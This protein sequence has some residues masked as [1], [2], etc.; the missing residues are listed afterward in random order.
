M[1]V[2]FLNH[3]IH[4]CGVYQYGLRLYNILSKSNDINYIYEE[5]DSFSEYYNVI[6]NNNNIKKILYNYHSCT[7]AWLN[8]KNINKQINS[9]G[10]IHESDGSF[11]DI[12]CNIN[13]DEIEINKSFS[14]PRPIFE[15]IIY[16]KSCS[17]NVNSFIDAYIDKN[18]PI[19]GSFGFGFDNKGFDKII[20]LINNNYNEAVIKLVIPI[21]H[22]D[23]NDKNMTIINIRN[24]L[25]NVPRKQ[26]I[27][28]M[29]T[30]T[31]FTNED[32]LLFLHSNTMNIFLY[33]TMPTRSISSVIDYAISVK[34]PVGISNS[35]MFRNIYNDSICLYKS[36]INY[37]LENSVKY[38]EKYLNKY[39][40]ENIINK[41]NLIINS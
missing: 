13:P 41:F 4:N 36:S 40:N 6:N 7:M 11:F 32:I 37:C 16:N 39:S 35:H 21:A 9:V 31:F 14:I 2:I 20:A 33:D 18:I 10:I 15:N 25:L 28:L 23:P 27:I 26:K 8:S 29:I 24:K 22:F 19:F 5:V 38:C 12:I 17:E 3:K 34:K 1:N 30:H